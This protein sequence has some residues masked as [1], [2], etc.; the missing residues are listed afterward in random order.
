MLLSP[1]VVFML[2]EAAFGALCPENCTATVDG[3]SFRCRYYDNNCVMN[4]TWNASR[5]S[6]IRLR[7]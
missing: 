7:A 5:A 2:L 1:F 6:A 4:I 3:S